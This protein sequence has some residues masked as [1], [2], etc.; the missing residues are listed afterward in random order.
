MLEVD[1]I[2]FKWSSRED[3]LMA[4][5]GTS[6]WQNITTH[7]NYHQGHGMISHSLK[8]EWGNVWKEGA[9]IYME[10]IYFFPSTKM[11]VMGLS[12]MILYRCSK[13]WRK[14]YTQL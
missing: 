13:M 12:L 11:I 8:L 2:W 7:V 5:E 10:D 6:S 1:H 9:F 3:F 4:L 14:D